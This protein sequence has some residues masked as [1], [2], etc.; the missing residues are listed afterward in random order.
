MSTADRPDDDSMARW[1]EAEALFDSIRDLEPARR[2]ERLRLLKDS[3]PVLVAWVEALLEADALART[4]GDAPVDDLEQETRLL[5]D[6]PG[7]GSLG[8]GD[9]VGPYFIL[10]IIGHGGMGSVYLAVRESEPLQF[11]ALKQ[12]RRGAT[13]DLIRR[14]HAERQLL[15]HFNHPH[16]VRLLETGT[17]ESGAP[18]LVMEF[19]DGP[20]L[21]ALPLRSPL[22]PRRI[23][24]IVRDVA[25]AIDHAHD[26]G[27][28]H[29]D[30]K[31][32]NILITKSGV[33]RVSDFGL[34]RPIIRQGQ[35]IHTHPHAIVGTPSFSAPEQIGARPGRNL[36]TVDIYSLGAILYFLLA[37]RPPYQGG[38]HVDLCIKVLNEDPRPPRAYR[39]QAPYDLETIAL[40]AM[41]RNPSDRFATAGE[42][43]EQLG[44]FLDGRPLTIRRPSPITRLGRWAARHRGQLAAAG[45]LAVGTL[46]ASIDLLT[47]ENRR[48]VADAQAKESMRLA[49][50]LIGNAV[51]APEYIS[52]AVPL[53]AD[54]THNYILATHDL[55]ETALRDIPGA[56]RDVEL[57]YRTALIN[58]TL[59]ESFRGRGHRSHRAQIL[60]HLDRSVALLESV[61][62]ERPEDPWYRYNLFRS[63]SH[64]GLAH[65]SWTDRPDFAASEADHL[66]ALE[67][68]Q[69]LAADR[70]ESPTEPECRDAI[71][72]Q[73]YHLSW[74]YDRQQ[75]WGKSK[76]HA[77]EA[78]KIARELVS[79]AP[80][81][82][83]FYGNLYRA[84]LALTL[85]ALVEGRPETA[86]TS[87][88][89]A[90]DAVARLIASAPDQA[91]HQYERAASLHH[92]AR[93]YTD[94]GRAREAC[95]AMDESQAIMSRLAA[96]FPHSAAFVSGYYSYWAVCVR[97]RHRL[98]LT[99]E[100][101]LAERALLAEL[102]T[103]L[104][105]D[106][107]IA[108]ADLR[109][110]RGQFPI[111]VTASSP[112]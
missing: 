20:N 2:L 30:L 57:R 94:L 90:L 109:D 100:A 34:A 9:Q 42:M 107:P 70:P 71:A 62:E 79:E 3:D 23:A 83:L 27:I 81:N 76:C 45:V 36:P 53:G 103:A 49:W 52:K 73:H 39:P 82:P 32:S 96:D 21:G 99:E 95:S 91:Q 89:G 25:L 63:L 26:Q 41:A 13:P 5:P 16:I 98:G 19:I 24:S 7:D 84:E 58:F 87:A 85:V 61:L 86:V 35:A 18:Y 48:L 1:N 74:C 12:I 6:L 44:R 56:G 111:S 47:V 29:R 15:A 108:A 106:R 78:R 8:A 10:G 22:P 33:P 80:D 69:D 105:D 40:K 38:S 88:Q 14:F 65:G 4:L 50:K 43:A 66:R 55:F 104:A 11:V 51:L 112:P 101:L 64:R 31:P 46:V 97:M 37:G 54:A 68:I 75:R 72:Y 77:L 102:D 67:V 60:R 17:D 110:I 59:A 28:V 92:L 93:A